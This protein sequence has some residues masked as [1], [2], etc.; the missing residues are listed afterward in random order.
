MISIRNEIQ[1][2]EDLQTLLLAVCEN[3]RAAVEDSGQYA[4]EIDSSITPAH[5]DALRKT[6]L[7]ISEEEIGA[8]QT[9]PSL[10]STVRNVLRDYKERAEQY[11]ADLRNRLEE[12]AN[13]LQ[14]VLGA[15]T[16]D[17]E[18]QEKKLHREMERLG[19]VAA[20]D[21][22]DEL[23]A[24]VLELK[25]SLEACVTEIEKRNRVTLAELNSEI[26]ALQK[27]VDLLSSPAGKAS[28]VFGVRQRVEAEMAAGNGF[29]LLFVRVRNLE[30]IR[31]RFGPDLTGRVVQC[32]LKR[33][34]NLPARD[35]SVG[36]WQE[37]ILCALVPDPEGSAVDLARE[38]NKRLAGKYVFTESDKVVEISA[39]MITVSMDRPRDYTPERT[40]VHI[41][42]TLA[43]LGG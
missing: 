4:I 3:Y 32:A 38:A 6:A 15:L 11:L 33:L 29:L 10:R 37:G 28:S 34:A 43:L 9:L 7:R 13:A 30:S 1:T 42:E 31:S 35:V 8:A 41:K 18:D 22:L 20:I 39:Q 12:H 19:E 2:A 17:S 21:N 27:Q 5:R 25:R 40:T 14:S 16:A 26:H 23:R 24:G 36:C